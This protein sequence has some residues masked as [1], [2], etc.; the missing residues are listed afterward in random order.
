M[1]NEERARALTKRAA[2]TILGS[3]VVGPSFVYREILEAI[4]TVERE[5]L[6]RAAKECDR[7]AK[8]CKDEAHKGGNFQ[9]LIARCEEATYNAQRIRALA[10]PPE[11][12]PDIARVA[13]GLAEKFGR[14]LG[15][16]EVAFWEPIA[17]A[18]LRIAEDG[19]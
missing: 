14:Q 4:Q 9:H 5:T 12:T 10:Q 1:T 3:M 2:E 11:P 19:R 18:A 8:F 15:Y 16:T 6:E 17:R 13:A 7:H